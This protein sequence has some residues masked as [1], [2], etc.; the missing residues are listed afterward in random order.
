ACMCCAC[1]AWGACGM[2]TPCRQPVTA[3][4]RARARVDVV[5]TSFISNRTAEIRRGPPVGG[6]CL[7][8]LELRL[9]APGLG[10]EQVLEE[11]GFLV[12]AVGGHPQLFLGSL[13]RRAR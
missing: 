6:Q 7:L 3:T 10:L 13:V 11:G 5:L 1:T 12:V 2:G 9:G 8:V 4:V